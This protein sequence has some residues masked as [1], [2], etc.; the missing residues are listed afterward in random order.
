M[1][2]KRSSKRSSRRRRTP[3]VVLLPPEPDARIGWRGRYRDPDSGRIV[4]ETLPAA[5]STAEQRADW[6]VR[7]AKALAL[8]RVELESGATPK[9]GTKFDDA[10]DR[11]FK[12]HGNLRPRTLKGYR[13]AADKLNAFAKRTALKSADDLT[14]PRLVAFRAELVREKYHAQ[15]KGA[16]RGAR[17]ETARARSPWT[18]NRELRAVR[19]VLGYLRRLGLL[20]RITSD[21]LSDSLSRLAVSVE[22]IDYR[23]P[24]ELRALLEAALR[25]DAD[26]Y[27]ETRAEH[28]G[29]ATRGTTPRY[30]PIAPIVA[31]ALLTGMRAGE[32]IALDWRN[33]DLEALD[34]DGKAVGEIHVTA[35]S[36][37]K[38]ARTVG[39]EVSPALRKM[40]AAM[41]LAA[42]RPRTGSVFGVTAHEADAAIGR[43][44]KEY[45]APQG[46]GFQA[47]RRTCGTF[48][49]NAPGIFGAASA[50][51]S[52]KQ[53]GHSVTVAEKHYVDVMRGIPRDARDLE[54]AMQITEQMARVVASVSAPRPHEHARPRAVRAPT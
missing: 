30:T 8:R 39:L 7:K 23:K 48:L 42:G 54:S 9:T 51:R 20:P 49:T 11:Y 22:R 36:K 13:D 5:L 21:I 17:R 28:A 12:D 3:G 27:D 33:V 32:L 4:R 43:L 41:H 18:V 2:E 6:A 38:R 25:H 14:G 10:I 1:P 24:H 46:S 35:A 45:G 31:A 15:A 40:L 26:T 44:A 50:Y 47:L 19:T 53:L 37:T 16:K 34:H 52:A 29:L